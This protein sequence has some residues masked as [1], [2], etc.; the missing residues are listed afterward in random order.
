MLVVRV[1]NER[2]ANII[3]KCFWRYLCHL[4][5]KNMNI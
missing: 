1:T 3:V 5:L 2:Y 4:K